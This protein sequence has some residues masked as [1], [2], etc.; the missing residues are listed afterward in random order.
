[1]IKATTINQKF[2]QLSSV[3]CYMEPTD[4]VLIFC[5]RKETTNRVC[6]WLNSQLLKAQKLSS[7]SSQQ[8]RESTLAK[9]KTGL[10][11]ILVATDVASRGLDIPSVEAVINFDFPQTIENY[12]HRIGRTGRAGRKGISYTFID[13]RDTKKIMTQLVDVLYTA[14]QTVP[15]WLEHYNPIGS[16]LHYKRNRYN[17]SESHKSTRP[18]QSRPSSTETEPEQDID[19]YYL[20]QR[21]LYQPQNGYNGSYTRPPP[22]KRPPRSYSNGSD[23]PPR[24]VPRPSVKPPSSKP[25]D[26]SEI[27]DKLKN[28]DP[29][30]LEAI[31][32]FLNQL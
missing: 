7:D 5:N 28:V 24:V 16:S 12:V 32:S 22:V 17:S 23:K 8:I 25:T 11:K 19:P 14:E 3:I 2:E 18:F 27:V 29:K 4:K 1:M 10:T 6:E 31:M 21:A 20:Q 30:K 13:L 9:F 15:E 26:S